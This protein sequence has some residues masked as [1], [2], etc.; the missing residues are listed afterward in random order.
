[1]AAFYFLALLGIPVIEIVV[2]VFARRNGEKAL[3]I[4]IWTSLLIELICLL[5][6]DS[7][8]KHSS[9][10]NA[11]DLSSMFFIL[12]VI[13]EIILLIALIIQ[14]IMFFRRSQNAWVKGVVIFLICVQTLVFGLDLFFAACDKRAFEEKQ[15]QPIK[16][17]NPNIEEID[18]VEHVKDEINS[19]LDG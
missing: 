5:F 3:P 7:W 2:A 19:A 15:N 6:M 10:G 12:W 13:L 4:V 14:C 1:M 11:K 8:A 16:E 17:R 18:A 9:I